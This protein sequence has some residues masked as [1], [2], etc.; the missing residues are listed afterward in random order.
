MAVFTAFEEQLRAFAKKADGV[1]NAVV[2]KV[3]FDL[4]TA[5]VLK[6]PVGDPKYWKSP[7]PPGYVGGRFRGNWQYGLDQINHFTDFSIDKSGQPTIAAIVGKV[8]ER[9]LGHIH[10][11][12]NT[13]PYANRLEDGWSHRQAP[14]GVVGITVLEFEPMVRAAA[15]ELS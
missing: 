12:T 8:Q 7:P 14:T 3:I 5:I 15:A 2:K 6:S 11:I 10:Y 13:L 4:S 1:A 9:V